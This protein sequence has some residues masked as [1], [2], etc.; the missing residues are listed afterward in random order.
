MPLSA[1]AGAAGGRGAATL[2]GSAAIGAQFERSR[3][4]GGATSHDAARGAGNCARSDHGPRST[5]GLGARGTARV[6]TH[7]AQPGAMARAE[8]R[9]QGVGWVGAALLVLGTYEQT[10]LWAALPHAGS[11]RRARRPSA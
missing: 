3:E 1:K 2:C 5:S 8:G 7:G 10:A 11:S 9:R 6:A 4:L